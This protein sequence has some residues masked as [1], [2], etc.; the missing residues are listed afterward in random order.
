MRPL[1]LALCAPMLLAA[2]DRDGQSI[3]EGK[4]SCLTCHALHGQGGSLGPDLSMI[5]VTRTPASLRLALINP[6]AEIH[7][8]YL[9]LVLTTRR[10]QTIE[11]IALNEDDVSIQLRDRTGVPRSFLK[12]DLREFHREERSLMPAFA[13]TLSSTELNDLLSYLSTLRGSTPPPAARTREIARVAENL[14]WLT[15]ADRDADER[16]ETLLDVLSLTNGMTIADIGSGLGY[17]TWRLARRVAPSGKVIA[18]DVQQ[19]MLDQTAAEAK[20]R[21]TP[22]IEL[23]LGLPHD[24]RLAPNSCDLIFVANSYHEFADPPAMLASFHR[25]LRP[26]GRLVVLEYAREARGVPI[27]QLHKMSLDDLRSEIEPAGFRLER[28]LDFL[29]IQHGVILSKIR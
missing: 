22:N 20:R 13:A 23:S 3:F 19:A 15:R 17:Y 2:S 14:G 6:S 27:S 5:A 18:I 28:I 9:T 1:L 25:A 24:P 21:N 11:G 16:P 10:G 26:N 12:S 4:G 29:P 8:E 7:D